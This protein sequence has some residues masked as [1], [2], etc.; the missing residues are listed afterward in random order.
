VLDDTTK[1]G[2][3]LKAAFGGAEA[4]SGDALQTF[5]D[6]GYVS[7]KKLMQVVSE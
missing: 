4:V 6:D 1:A 7:A 5:I 2:T 3:L